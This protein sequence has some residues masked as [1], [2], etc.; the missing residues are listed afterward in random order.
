MLTEAEEDRDKYA[1]LR[2][3]GV[4]KRMMLKTIAQQVGFTFALPLM[5]G[6]AHGAAALSAFSQL[7]MMDVTKPV[8][9]WMALYVAVYAL[10]YVFTVWNFY[11]LT[12]RGIV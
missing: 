6:L 11:K 12:K 9:V 3:I 8:L 10:Y 2:K 7:F 4:S 1:I 5:A